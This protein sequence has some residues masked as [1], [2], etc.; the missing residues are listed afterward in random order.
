MKLMKMI[1]HLLTGHDGDGDFDERYIIGL[2]GRHS[3]AAGVD[4]TWRGVVVV[5]H[6]EC[7]P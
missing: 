4:Q 3:G 6:D 2:A 5:V 7:V 1:Y